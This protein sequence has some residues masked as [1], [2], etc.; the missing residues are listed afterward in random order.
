MDKESLIS[1]YILTPQGRYSIPRLKSQGKDDE[2]KIL[3]SLRSGG[4]TPEDIVKDT[5][6]DEGTLQATIPELMDEAGSG[7]R[8]PREKL[9]SD[10]FRKP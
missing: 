8:N 6:L 9:Y 5:G 10:L 3:E 2:A 7:K 4:A 1:Y